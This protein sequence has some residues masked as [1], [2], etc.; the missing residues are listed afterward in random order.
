MEREL[1][2]AHEVE[3]AAITKS[4]KAKAAIAVGKLEKQRD[5]AAAKIAERDQRIAEIRRGAEDDRA[6][7]SAVADEL[8]SLY[9]DPDE[10]IK[11]AR[12]VDLEEIEENEFNLN[13]PRY[14]DTFEPEPR[15][16]V[17]DALKALHDAEVKAT[18]AERELTRLLEAVGYAR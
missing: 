16:E 15:I 4:D 17:K 8:V 13:V 3:N 14:V 5:T 12:V 9:G 18:R 1:T 2:E 6:D 11:H 7:V 10:L